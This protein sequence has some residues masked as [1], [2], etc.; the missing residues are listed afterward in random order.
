MNA[1]GLTFDFR[2]G[3]V[4]QLIDANP[5]QSISE[6]ARQVN[7]SNS[8]LSHLFKARTGQSLNVFLARRRL[9][10]AARLLRFTDMRVKEITY[11]V[12]YGQ[13]PS[14]VRAFKKKFDCSPTTYRSQQ[15]T[16]PQKNF[17]S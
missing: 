13:Q 15:R 9:E 6:L 10:K 11:S 1:I 7:L 16:P 5:S 14:F 8:R 4:L 3:K 12:G 17:V 2:I